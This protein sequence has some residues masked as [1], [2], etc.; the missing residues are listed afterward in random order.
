MSAADSKVPEKK[1]TLL[2]LDKQMPRLT[3]ANFTE[4]NKGLEEV[5]YYADWSPKLIDIAQANPDEAWDGSKSKNKA[6]QTHRRLAYALIKMTVSRDINHL[7]IDIRPGDVKE[8][9]SRIF[10]RFCR[11]TPGALREIKLEL[12]AYTQQGSGTTL[13]VYASRLKDKHL[14]YLKVQKGSGIHQE[15]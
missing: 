8:Q 3:T 1:I 5:E 9:Y 6:T 4:W 15:R 11:L 14:H 2:E 10:N 12:E 7:L 13:E